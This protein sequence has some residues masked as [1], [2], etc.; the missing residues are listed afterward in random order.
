MTEKKTRYKYGDVIIRERKGRYYVYVLEIVNGEM[1]E[2]YLAP[3]VDVVRSYAKLKEN[4]GVG[5]G[6]PQKGKWGPPGFEP[7]RVGWEGPGL[8]KGRPVGFKQ[9]T[10]PPP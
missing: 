8:I 6:A 10:G 2:R 9:K 4:G 5:G 3:L 1:K 7:G